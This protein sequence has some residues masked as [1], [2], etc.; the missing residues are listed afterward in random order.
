MV[1]NMKE[2]NSKRS[3]GKTPESI[4]YDGKKIDYEE[5]KKKKGAKK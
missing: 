1:I 4:N 3:K 2:N 5:Y